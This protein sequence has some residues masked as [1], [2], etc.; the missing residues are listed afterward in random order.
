MRGFTMI[1]LMITLAIAGVLMA[2]AVPGMR[3]L[4]AGRA[5]ASQS[6]DLLSA[7]RFARAE[8]IKRGAPVTI[9]RTTAAAPK[10]CST[11]AAGS[12]QYWVVFADGP[13]AIGTLDAD[14][15]VLRVQSAPA[16]SVTF[17]SLSGRKFFAFQS[18]G[19]VITAAD[20]DLPASIDIQPK[21]SSGSSSFKRYERQIC[22]NRLG[23]ASLIDGNGTCSS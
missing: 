8:A 19:V 13:T 14:E 22:L 5:V 21:V 15:T 12:W 20:T 23:R 16:G 17:P 4:I 2:L 3:N 18:T 9:C 6:D 7:M 10:V 1:E 11:T